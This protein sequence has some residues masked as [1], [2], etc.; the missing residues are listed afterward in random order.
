VQIVSIG[1]AVPSKLL[2]NEDV[3]E[4]LDASCTSLSEAHRKTYVKLA[5]KTIAKAGGHSRYWCADDETPAQL[6]DVAVRDALDKA[7]LRAASIDLV[8]YCSVTKGVSEPGQSFVVAN[9]H[10]IKD[11]ICFDISEACN[12]FVRAMQI[13]SSLLSQGTVKTAMI[14]TG[15]F[16]MQEKF[17]V[18]KNFSPKSMDD[19]VW[20]FPSYTFGEM[21][22]A[23]IVE[24]SDCAFR[25]YSSTN[26]D[27][28]NSCVMTEKW[29]V[30][31]N[32]NDFRFSDVDERFICYGRE[33]HEEGKKLMLPMVERLESTGGLTGNE[34]V[35]THSSSKYSWDDMLDE[36][37][38]A[39]HERL[40][41]FPKYGNIVTATLPASL[42]EMGR[43]DTDFVYLSGAA[44]LSVM[45]MIG[46]Y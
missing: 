34:P 2:L 22:A 23:M 17:H 16:W 25:F 21:A 8:V 30:E 36:S 31:F 10:G 41:V 3:L 40:M 33:L 35:I 28:I 29:N 13:V 14:V 5:A 24:R 45:G 43:R 37:V 44:G 6:T 7:G 15:E 20:S 18:R 27:V 9:R 32:G 4:L 1:R 42:Y 12:G 11:A 46:H 38:L 26:T 39:D 19:F